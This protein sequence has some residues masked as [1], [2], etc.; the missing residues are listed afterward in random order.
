MLTNSLNRLL[1]GPD[2]PA[3][4]PQLQAWLINPMDHVIA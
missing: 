2:L 1:D 3:E 4:L